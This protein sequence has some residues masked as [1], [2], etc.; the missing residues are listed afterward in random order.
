MRFSLTLVLLFLFF[1]NTDAQS[2]WQKI[3]ESTINRSLQGER[4][5]TPTAYETFSLN[6]TVLKKD[7]KKVSDRDYSKTRKKKDI[8]EV[9]FPDGNMVAFDVWNAPV[10]AP[11]IAARYPDIKSYK[12]VSEDGKHVM[13]FVVS[14]AGFNGVISSAEGTIYLDPI[15]ENNIELYQSYYIKD[16][17]A[18]DPYWTTCGNE[19]H[20]TDVKPTQENI[21]RS[22]ATIPL[23]TYR[24][25]IACT[26]EYGVIQGGTVENV[27]QQYNI[28]AARLAQIYELN[29]SI[30][31]I[32]I[33]E[34]DQLIHLN[35]D[36]DP[37]FFPEQGRELIGENTEAINNIINS[38]LYDIGHVFTIRCTDGVAGIAARGSVCNPTKAAGVS[39]VGNSNLLSF[40]NN[41]IAH[42]VGHQFDASHS[43]NNCPGSEENIATGWAYEPGSGTTIMSYSGLCGASNTGVFNDYFSVGSL[44]QI[45]EF[46]RSAIAGCGVHSSELNTDPVIDMPYESGFYIP[47]STPFVLDAS[48]TDVDGDALTYA[49]DQYD[50][51]PSNV[52]G[53]PTGNAPLF[54][55][56]YPDENSMRYFPRLSSVRNNIDRNIEILPTYER[57]LKFRF[58]A[59]DLNPIGTAAV[60]EEVQ[61]NVAGNSGPF[62]VTQPNNAPDNAQVGQDL[63]IK[64]DVS[65]TDQAPVNC[66]F[67][68]IL[69]STDD[70]RTFDHVLEANTLNDGQQIVRLPDAETTEARIKVESVG[71][72]FY[73]MGN[74]A[75]NIGPATEPSYV[76]SLSDNFFDVCAPENVTIN[77][78]SSAFVGYNNPVQFS[79][80][81]GLPEGVEAVFTEANIQPDGSTSLNFNISN[82]VTT[83]EYEV[84]LQSTSGSETIERTIFLNITA[85]DFEDLSLTYPTNGSSGVEQLPTLTW[86]VA[87][88]AEHYIFELATNPSFG[89]ST[90]EF[91]DNLTT[92]SY[93]P[94]A[95]LE[96]STLYYWRVTAVNKCKIGTPTE[97]NTFGTIALSCKTFV[98]QDMPKN[99]SSAGSGDY[100][101]SLEVFVPEEGQIAAVAVKKVRGDHQQFSNLAFS[102]ESPS[103][104]RAKMVSNKCGSTSGIFDCGFEDSSPISITCPFKEVYKPEEPLEIFVGE[105]T[106]GTW[107]FNINDQTAGSGG[108]F[109]EFE[110]QICSNATLDAPVLVNNNVLEVFPGSWAKIKPP[111]LLVEDANNTADELIYT[112]VELPKSGYLDFLGADVFIGTQFSQADIDASRISYFNTDESVVSD[113]FTFTCID[114]EGGWI[115]ITPFQINLDESFTSGLDDIANLIEVQ[116]LPNPVNE[117]STISI[118]NTNGK[119]YN[120]SLT[121]L[122]GQVFLQN[123]FNSDQTIEVNVKDYPAGIYFISVES[124]G[125]VS[126]EKMVVVK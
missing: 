54:I 29:A 117:V 39:C 83:G 38:N 73:D 16:Q 94:T 88:N 41:V 10:M 63:E 109:E 49:W 69:L 42:E 20:D 126:Y 32:L 8:I 90:V 50:L 11:G 103:S 107:K 95:S 64:W 93:E 97:I 52:L 118:N 40:T 116:V 98:S 62:F 74:N 23:R 2:A 89:S 76:Y 31:F 70:G 86:E 13:R 123:N 79:I 78:E 27:M 99:I 66:Q 14:R 25:A 65:N 92:N 111:S 43:W 80:V 84:I 24:M 56:I 81:S 33:D 100:T 28:V 91:S 58:V 72:I 21:T 67:V 7:L 18:P 121:N 53:T 37:Y 46:T 30:S 59:K 4:I 57:S 15:Y 47:K 104:T 75:F 1:S 120:F 60:W 125:Q 26:G 44:V 6:M 96:K 68:N 19:D 106:Q 48:A 119:N 35:P 101:V 77:I 114:G 5:V 87:R 122:S 34:T 105:S 85:T 9:P 45:T 124:S 61:F 82:E 3:D 115:D 22:I 17:E 55:P 112:I 108:V 110:L 12:G 113:A 36:T 51:G 102:L 71:N